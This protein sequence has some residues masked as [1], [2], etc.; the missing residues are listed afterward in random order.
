MVN[1]HITIF[2]DADS[3]PNKVFNFVKNFCSDKNIAFTPVAN[4]TKNVV[5]SVIVTTT[6][7]AADNYI[8]DHSKI[9]DIVITRDTLFAARLVKKGITAINDRGLVFTKNNITDILKDRDFNLQLAQLGL[10]NKIRNYNDK[11]FAAFVKCFTKLVKE[12]I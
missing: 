10:V 4:S 9:G 12:I 2:I 11:H 8:I 3:C 5:G 7:D 6:R 1:N